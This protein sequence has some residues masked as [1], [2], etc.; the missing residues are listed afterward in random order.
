MLATLNNKKMDQYIH[1]LIHVAKTNIG[2]P[3]T[4][5]KKETEESNSVTIIPHK[6]TRG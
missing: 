2:T 5:K 3:S 6:A 4:K 1:W